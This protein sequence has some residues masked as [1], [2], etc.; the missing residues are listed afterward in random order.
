ML[1]GKKALDIT[2]LLATLMNNEYA[3]AGGK[4]PAPAA[5]STKKK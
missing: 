3:A 1:Y 4:A 5:P 2:D